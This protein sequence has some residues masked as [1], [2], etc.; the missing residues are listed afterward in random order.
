MRKRNSFRVSLAKPL[1]PDFEHAALRGRS[2]AG[3]CRSTHADRCARLRQTTLP[4]VHPLRSIRRSQ[5]RGVSRGRA[6]SRCRRAS[7]SDRRFPTQTSVPSAL[8]A[9]PPPNSP[10]LQPGP[11]ARTPSPEGSESR[12]RL[13]LVSACQWVPFT[14]LRGPSPLG[15]GIG[16]RAGTMPP[17]RII[18]I[19]RQTP[20][21]SSVPRQGCGVDEARA[22]CLFK[23]RKGHGQTG[24]PPSMHTD[25]TFSP[26]GKA[27]ASV[28]EEATATVREKKLP[29]KMLAVLWMLCLP[30][31]LFFAGTRIREAKLASSPMPASHSPSL[32]YGGLAHR[33]R[34][35]IGR[36]V[37][38]LQFVPSCF[39]RSG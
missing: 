33:R 21:A 35:L 7:C 17:R 15:G 19:A 30:C 8:A 16:K 6:Q 39:V 32:E 9:R 23:E 14:L 26:H 24:K 31:V 10:G 28:T 37:G 25:V 36:C 27:P 34:V 5:G 38:G 18:I 11:E 13:G 1:Y 2:P 22:A 3:T 29:L 20:G 4:P 12:T